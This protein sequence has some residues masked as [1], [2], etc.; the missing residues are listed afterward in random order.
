[1][2]QVE[3]SEMLGV[4]HQAVS[5]WETGESIPDVL[6]LEKLSELYKVSI[7]EI[8]RQEEA[9]NSVK[10]VELVNSNYS[11]ILVGSIMIL[12]LFCVSTL[13]L[14]FAFLETEIWI[15]IIL[16]LALYVF[17]TIPFIYVN[18]RS[19]NIIQKRKY[20]RTVS[21]SLVVSVFISVI[22]AFSKYT[23]VDIQDH[24]DFYYIFIP[25]A[26]FLL[27]FVDYV[28]RFVNA[29]QSDTIVNHF[30]VKLR[31]KSI[32]EVSLLRAFLVFAVSTGV[33]FPVLRG[34]ENTG[35]YGLVYFGAAIILSLNVFYHYKITKLISLI[36]IIL[37]IVTFIYITTLYGVYYGN[38]ISG[39]DTI[40]S[41]LS[42]FTGLSSSIYAL[43]LIGLFVYKSTKRLGNEFSLL[44][45][46]VFVF[47]FLQ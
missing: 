26:V 42:F 8:V 23:E 46:S 6:M 2:T 37:N 9:E 28:V 40:G 30:L 17:S 43:F 11:N 4:T 38:G 16:A 39:L 29:E 44:L 27:L 45:Y 7:D 18:A 24:S 1:M 34:V 10:K 12:L 19:V 21:D 25:S 22:V 35:I 3:L 36:L 31:D 32:V 47:M 41:F 33:L 20:L 13:T 14:Y 5:R 15:W